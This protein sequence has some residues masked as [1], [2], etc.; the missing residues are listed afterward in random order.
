MTDFSKLSTEDLQSYVNGDMSKVSTE[1]LKLITSAESTSEA[2]PYEATFREALQNIPQGK[3]VMGGMLCGLTGETI[4]NIGAATE[5]VSP[6]YGKPI[7]QVGQAMTNVSKEASP[8]NIDY[9]P[10]PATIGAIGSY[11]AP[12]SLINKGGELLAA[13]STMPKLAKAL[14]NL[15]GNMGLGFLTTEGTGQEGLID[16]AKSAAISGG[17]SLGL[18]V[19]GA[20]VNK[21]YQGGKAMLEPFYE[22]G[23]EAIMARA[24]RNFSGGQSDEAITNLLASTPTVKGSLPTVGQAS[25]IP[26][27]A[28]AERALL[29]ASPEATNMLTNRQT[30]NALA[31]TKALE[32]IAPPSRI[33]KYTDLRT[34]MGEDLYE[35]ALE[36]GMDFSKLTPELQQQIQGLIKS[37]AIKKAMTQAQTNALNKGID[38]GNPSGSLRGLHQTKI[39]LDEQIADVE[40]KLL[41]DGIPSAKNAQL[42]G[43]KGAKERLLGF[44]ESPQISPDYK[45]ARE[46][47][48][49]LS[50]PVDQ[51]EQIAKL[52]DKTVSAK[53]NTIYTDRFFKELEKIK[54]DGLLS[55]QQIARLEAIGD[56]L[57]LKSFADTSG[58]GVGSDTMQKLAYA[59]AANAIGLPNMLRGTSGGQMAARAAQKVGNTLYSNA[60]KEITNKMAETFLS[61]QRAAELMQLPV[62]PALNTN[63]AQNL[64]R[65]LMLQQT[66]QGTQP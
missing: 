30:Q 53:D 57:Q 48:A 8:Y 29:N 39:A 32:N 27:L 9:V 60:N 22:K 61:P 23:Q 58:R 7:A 21:A 31:R 3:R 41:R 38:I 2:N 44:I 1:G 13:S 4:K 47:F 43:L 26:S 24:L 64:A 59:N 33:E 25:A 45:I 14:T 17:V 40:A 10:T 20:V 11:F 18:P 52:A 36:K 51:L 54:K 12:T 49:K 34:K 56:D 37:P 50:K 65:M 55:K 6:K 28:A 62:N 63:Q 15:G 16:R 46:T 35:P 66:T 5:L 42:D 19:V